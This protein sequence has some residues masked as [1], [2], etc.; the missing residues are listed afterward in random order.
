[1]HGALASAGIRET[2]VLIHPARGMYILLE[3]SGH[4]LHTN[5]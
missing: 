5:F 1:M 4:L 2:S 3:R